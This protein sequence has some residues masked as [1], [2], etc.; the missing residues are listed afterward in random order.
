MNIPIVFVATDPSFLSDS[1]ATYISVL[2]VNDPPVIQKIPTITFAEDDSVYYSVQENFKNYVSD[3]D[4]PFDSLKFIYVYYPESEIIFDTLN[5]GAT[6]LFKSAPN[7]FGN[8]SLLLRVTDGIDTASQNLYFEVT[9]VNDAPVF[10]GLPE[11][12]EFTNDTTY[13]LDIWEYVY[14]V[15]TPDSLLTFDFIRSSDSL[16]TVYDSKQGILTI[17]ARGEIEGNYSLTV[18]AT[19][20]S[21]AVVQSVIPVTVEFSPD[22]WT[23]QIPVTYELLQNYPN[24]FNP[25]TTIRFGVPVTSE[26]RIELYNVLGEKVGL[27]YEGIRDEGFFEITWNPVNMPSGI[28]LYAMYAKSVDRTRDKFIV[29]KLMLLK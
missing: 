2:P 6:L 13:A 15:E 10:Q 21:G 26:V 22:H 12:I 8:D 17:S 29:K 4:N 18:K 20:D 5:A 1:A 14:D 25:S 28:Y 24:P 7:W 3:I 11:S 27:L 23:N 19:D 16:I 9:S